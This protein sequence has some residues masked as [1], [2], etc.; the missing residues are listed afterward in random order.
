MSQT[1]S[2]PVKPLLDPGKPWDELTDS[3]RAEM[4]ARVADILEEQSK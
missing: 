3:E 4:A 2:Q 1:A